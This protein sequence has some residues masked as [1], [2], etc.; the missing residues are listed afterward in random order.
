MHRRLLIA[1]GLCATSAFAQQ[2]ASAP[3]SDGH[4]VPLIIYASAP[5]ATTGCAPLA[6]LSHGAGGSENGLR[7]LAVALSNMGYTAIVMGHSESGREAVQASV[8]AKGLRKGVQAVVADPAAEGARLLDV[9]ATL[10]YADKRCKAPFRVLLGH[11]MGAETVMLE[12]GAHDMIGIDPA[13]PGKSRFDAYVA[14]SPEGSG[15]VF[16]EH[17]W[18]GIHKPVLVLTGTLD[19]ALRGGPASRLVPWHGLPGTST[20]CQWQGVIDNATHANMGGNGPGADH[21]TPYITSTVA[22]LL[23]GVRANACTLPT[24]VS[25]FTLQAK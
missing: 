2:R 15:V 12:A 14:L 24:P 23:T 11:S 9:T 13:L 18:A 17:A 19:G 21:A 20:H 25:G 1:L 6:V 10:A 8:V 5:A 3:R 22:A 16:T 4:T 7:Y